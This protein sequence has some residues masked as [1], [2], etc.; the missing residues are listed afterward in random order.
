MK[1]VTVEDEIRTR[2]GINNLVSK[3]NTCYKVIGEAEDGLE[4]IR[5]IEQL[6]PDLVIADIKMPNMDGL[7][8]LRELRKKG[9]KVKIVFLSGYADFEL[10]QK[11]IK[12]GACDYMLKPITLEDM[13]NTLENVERDLQAEKNARYQFLS[14]ESIFQSIINGNFVDIEDLKNLL[15]L[16]YGID[17]ERDFNLAIL[18]M[19][20]TT[21]KQELIKQI[22]TRTMDKFWGMKYFIIEYT[23]HNQIV[24]LMFG[25]ESFTGIESAL[26]DITLKNFHAQDFQNAVIGL[27][28]VKKLEDLNSSLTCLVKSLNWSKVI[29][30][31]EVITPLKI[32]RLSTSTFKNPEKIFQDTIKT[33]YSQD[34]SKLEKHVNGFISYCRT[35]TYP[36]EKVT[37]AFIYYTASIISLLKDTNYELYTGIYKANILEDISNSITWQETTTPLLDLVEEIKVKCKS[38]SKS[39]S[40]IVNRVLNIIKDHYHKGLSLEQISS[41]LHITPEYLSSVF[42]KEVGKN[43][44]NYLT[45]YR[46]S[47]AKELLMTTDWKIYKVAEE[48]GYS[49]SKYFCAVFKKTTGFSPGEYVQ[50]FKG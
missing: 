8:M 2:K 37:E 31:E 40:M 3:I 33:I 46:I 44:T 14:P 16:K 19:K 12:L 22:L 10:A 49:D 25:D 35:E 4:G 42:N 20:N 13:K 6:S 21:Q 30:K 50:I 45:E 9:L 28:S 39:Y 36:P 26:R 1:I 34:Y 27:S 15:V 48:V 38:C 43:Y 11:A 24:I 7:D 23:N 29:G 47:K 32:A 5:I 41:D 18:Y 17:A